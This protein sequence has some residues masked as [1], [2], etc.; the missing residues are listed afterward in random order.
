MKYPPFE[1]NAVPDPKLLTLVDNL[2]AGLDSD[3]AVGRNFFGGREG[4]VD[5]LLGLV[6]DLCGEPPFTCLLRSDVVAGEYDVH[7]P[8]LANGAGQP[9]AT[10]TAWDGTQLDLGLAKGGLGAGV[11]NVAHHGELAAAS[12]GVAID[13]DN[14]GLLEKG[15]KLGPVLDEVIA[16]SGAEGQVLHFLDVC[17]GGKGALGAGEDDGANGLVGLVVAEGSIELE[18]EGGEEGIEGL[19]A[20]QLDSGVL[21]GQLKVCMSQGELTEANAGFWRRDEQMFI[22]LSRRVVAGKAEAT[23]GRLRGCPDG[24]S[25]CEHCGEEL[26]YREENR[27]RKK[28]ITSECVLKLSGSCSG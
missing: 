19:G 11:Y 6:K 20:V 12:E 23:C 13:G 9:L 27:E 14:Q 7:G 8:A 25:E 3:L 2:L 26:L 5:T 4:R 28:E 22:R 18:D 17:T 15:H 1:L 16:V 21:V 10:S 24:S